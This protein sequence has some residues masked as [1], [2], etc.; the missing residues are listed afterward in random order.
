MSSCCN[1]LNYWDS[2]IYT[3]GQIAITTYGEHQNGFSEMK[4][5]IAFL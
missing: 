2:V 4:L 5:Y 1:L 3:N